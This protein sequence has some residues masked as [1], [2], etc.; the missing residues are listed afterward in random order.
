MVM[1]AKAGILLMLLFFLSGLYLLLIP[2]RFFRN[3]AGSQKVRLS[4]L[5]LCEA[6]KQAVQSLT[7]VY[8]K[9]SSPFVPSL[10]EG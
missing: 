4:L 5:A 7:R 2:T 10:R 9:I 1:P 3:L 6:L 8:P